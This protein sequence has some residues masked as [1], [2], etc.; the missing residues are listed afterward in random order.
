MF[1]VYRSTFSVMPHLKYG[2]T[3]LIHDLI[4]LWLLCKLYFNKI[5]KGTDRHSI[6]L[7]YPQVETNPDD[8]NHIRHFKVVS[9][10]YKKLSK[11]KNYHTSRLLICKKKT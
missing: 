10:R 7:Q 11:I 9:E 8:P 3:S 6:S 1:E 4:P 5:T 2:T